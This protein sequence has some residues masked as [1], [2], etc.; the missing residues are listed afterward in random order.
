[1]KLVIECKTKTV[2]YCECGYAYRLRKKDNVL[3]HCGWKNNGYE[4]YADYL[5][6]TNHPV[7][8]K[9][10]KEFVSWGKEVA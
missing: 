5:E 3:V 4:S 6:N 10:S 1:M 9:D 2:N 7:E 8:H